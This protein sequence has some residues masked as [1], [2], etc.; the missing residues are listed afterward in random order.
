MFAGAHPNNDLRRGGTYLRV[1]RETDS[2][3]STVADDGDLV[4][5]TFRWHRTRRRASVIT[6][7]WTVPADTPPGR[8]RLRYDGDAR[9]SDG[10]IRAFSGTTEPFELLAPR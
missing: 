4:D 5:P 10:A 6:A 3:W 8:Y 7:T 1:Q 9:E 2:G